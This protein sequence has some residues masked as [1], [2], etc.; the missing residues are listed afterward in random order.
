M[1]HF[2]ILP[3]S[4]NK[5]LPKGQS[6]SRA[7]AGELG[8]HVLASE[9][10][11]PDTAALWPGGSQWTQTAPGA[12]GGSSPLLPAVGMP[13]RGR[14]LR[15]LWM[16]RSREGFRSG[17]G[18][19]ASSAPLPGVAVSRAHT[20]DLWPLPC[21]RSGSDR[22]R[23]QLREATCWGWIAGMGGGGHGPATPASRTKAG[24]GGF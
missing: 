21:C 24:Q 1:E 5:S 20:T 13:G 7:A 22:H 2:C 15:V 16:M 11:R 19:P 12:S 8:Q 14:G 23:L 18:G 10:P 17:C 3:A 6:R 9:R 4:Q